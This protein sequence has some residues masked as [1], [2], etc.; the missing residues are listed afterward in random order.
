MPIDPW[1]VLSADFG[2]LTKP[3]TA[4]V[5]LADMAMYLVLTF[6]VGLARKKHKIAAP[7]IEGPEAFKRVFRAHQNTLEQLAFHLPLLWLAAFA[8]DDVFAAAM[9]AVWILGRILYARGYYQKA[10]RRAKGFFVCLIANA[11][12]FFAVLASVIA[13]F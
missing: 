8:M 6:N 11:V 9:G 10:K 13:S 4:F 5:T 1:N 7:D 12:L 3:Y 2:T